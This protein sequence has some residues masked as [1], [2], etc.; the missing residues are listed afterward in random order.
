MCAQTNDRGETAE[1][2]TLRHAPRPKQPEL[3]YILRLAGTLASRQLLCFALG[4][5]LNTDIAACVAGLVDR[6]WAAQPV[7][8]RIAIWQRY[9]PRS[10]FFPT[11]VSATTPHPTARPAATD[12]KLLRQLLPP[13]DPRAAAA[14]HTLPAGDFKSVVREGY[15]E[16]AEWYQQ[17]QAA[18]A[19]ATAAAADGEAPAEGDLRATALHAATAASPAGAMVLDLGCG[20][21]ATPV[22]AAVLRDPRCL[23]L[24]AVDCSARVMSHIAGDIARVCP[25]VSGHIAR[26][27]A[28]R[29]DPPDGGGGG[30]VRLVVAD[31]MELELPP[32]SVDCVCAFFSVFHLPRAEHA[33]L[34]NKVHRWLRP[35]GT[36]VFNLGP[37]EGIGEC[38]TAT[39]FQDRGQ[40]M[41]WSSHSQTET[42]RLLRAA[43]LCGGLADPALQSAWEREGWTLFLYCKPPSVDGSILDDLV[44][45]AAD[46]LPFFQQAISFL[47]ATSDELLMRYA[48]EYRAFWLLSGQLQPADG[49]V[50]AGSEG[51]CGGA[52]SSITDGRRQGQRSYTPPSFPVELF[53][54]AHLLSPVAYQRDCHAAQVL[55]GARPLEHTCTPLHCHMLPTS[56][57]EDSSGGGRLAAMVTALTHA[58]GAGDDVGGLHG[59]MTEEWVETL[60]RRLREQCSFMASV[61]DELPAAHQRASLTIAAQLESYRAF[62]VRAGRAEEEVP[63]PGLLVDLLWHTHM[64]SPARYRR[65]CSHIA[66]RLLDHHQTSTDSKRCVVS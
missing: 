22:A 27:V 46:Q 28:H 39:S 59:V 56:S 5:F 43:G 34:F 35:G 30:R 16:C 60:V 31:M 10:I 4:H 13:A 65:E 25:G 9:A 53:W 48:R 7:E 37:S 52:T 1:E 18:A 40:P 32:C 41:A 61:L 36:C 17:T 2:L 45:P 58:E 29:T 47:D 21:A 3:L 15:D 54:R 44:V 20:S 24:T 62:L 33:A 6:A 12:T 11:S 63:V 57:A 42:A 51:K 66:G 55:C 14:A 49:T 19:A 23:G 38:V 50:A 8:Q 26:G 64:L